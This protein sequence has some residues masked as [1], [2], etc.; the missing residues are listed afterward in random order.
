MDFEF[1]NEEGN[2]YKSSG[3]QMKKTELGE[4]PKNWNIGNVR[5]LVDFQSGFAFKSELFDEKGTFRLIT[6][7]GVQDGFLD[8][9]GAAYINELPKKMPSYCLL[10]EGD[11]IMSLTGNVGRCC[12]VDRGNLLLNQRVVKL[13]PVKKDNNMFVYTMFRRE[14]FKDRLTSLARGTAQ[15]NLSPIETANMRIVIPTNDLIGSYCLY[16]EPIF[17]N[18]LNNIKENNNLSSLRDILLPKLMSGELSVDDIST[19]LVC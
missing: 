18:L 19:D 11:I 15:A 7:K 3:G 8:I 2:P 10:Q 6:I 9:N 17:S 16:G 5:D 12:I 14:E 13:R 1:P 4:I